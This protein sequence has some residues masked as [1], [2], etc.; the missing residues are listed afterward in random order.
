LKIASEI[1][2]ETTETNWVC[3]IFVPMLEFP[4]RPI[5]WQALLLRPTS[6]DVTG[7]CVVVYVGKLV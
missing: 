1:T 4:Y 7:R 2:F 5:Y 6:S 3:M